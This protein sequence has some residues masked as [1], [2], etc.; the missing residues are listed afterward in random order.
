VLGGGV[1]A[2]RRP[3]LHD[4]VLAG[5][6]EVVPLARVDIVTDRPVVGA[7]LTALDRWHEAGSPV[8]EAARTAIRRVIP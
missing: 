6:A 5:L 7:A 3:L 8:E 2:A 4:A 1:L